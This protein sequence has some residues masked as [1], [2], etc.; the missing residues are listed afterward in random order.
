MYF[1]NRNSNVVESTGLGKYHIELAMGK[2]SGNWYH[3]H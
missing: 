1:N 2:A 3:H